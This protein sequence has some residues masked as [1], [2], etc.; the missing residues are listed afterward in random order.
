MFIAVRTVLVVGVF[1]EVFRSVVAL[2]VDAEARILHVGDRPLHV[3]VVHRAV[4]RQAPP[5]GKLPA[6]AEG[7]GEFL[8]RDRRARADLPV[9]VEALARHPRHERRVGVVEAAVDAPLDH[10]LR[11]PEAEDLRREA[12]VIEEVAE[13]GR[14]VETDRVL[15][16][17]AV[18]VGLVLG[19]DL[20]EA[21]REV[22]RDFG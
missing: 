4:Q 15:D 5:L 11:A 21:A 14:G 16:R 22:R 18:V 3:A 9:V 13:V 2:V 7:E 8:I 19:V 10:A 12:L 6:A 20:D 1:I 17:H